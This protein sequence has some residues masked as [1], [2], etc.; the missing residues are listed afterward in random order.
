MDTRVI[1]AMKVDHGRGLLPA[2]AKIKWSGVRSKQGNQV[3][4]CMTSH[5]FDDFARLIANLAAR[6][7]SRRS[8]LR[9]AGVAGTVS[10]LP[11]LKGAAAP[12][13]RREIRALNQER[14]VDSLI[15]ETAFGLG[16]DR[17]QIFQF[18]RDEV[19]YDPYAGVLRGARGTLQGLAGNAADQ[20]ILLAAL[21]DASL[22]TT[23]FAIGEL[24]EEAADA[25][26][27]SAQWDADTVHRQVRWALRPPAIPGQPPD[28]TAEEAAFAE[29]LPDF[30]KRFRDV[31]ERSEADG[32]KTVTEA[33]AAAGIDIPAPATSLPDLERNQHVWLQAIEGTNWVGPQGT[34]I[35]RFPEIRRADQTARASDRG[36]HAAV[37]TVP[38]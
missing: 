23:R 6:S 33:L 24:S 17:N 36:E 5:W 14:T 10:I 28:L 3:G 7:E 16:Y 25:L 13:R 12:D 9:A 21:L 11:R 32:F 8:L 31:V 37:G 30:A 2:S 35:A 26:I 4:V 29:Q 15:D 19:A 27:G 38:A 1:L 34:P 18:V 22:I 20:A